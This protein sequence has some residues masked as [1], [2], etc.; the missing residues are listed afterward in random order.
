MG[1]I[2]HESTGMFKVSVLNEE[3]RRSGDW[4]GFV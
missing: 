3:E 4:A 1:V 2:V